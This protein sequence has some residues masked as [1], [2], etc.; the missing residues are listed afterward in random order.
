[1]KQVG[2]LWDYTGVYSCNTARSDVAP[3]DIHPSW[4]IHQK[5][6]VEKQI[7]PWIEKIFVKS[8][9][10]HKFIKTE[11]DPQLNVD[12]MNVDP[13]YR[14]FH[15]NLAILLLNSEVLPGAN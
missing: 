7:N 4:G 10:L 6:V 8:V 12:Y 9:F 15:V 2:A 3:W 13:M 14:D 11:T 1:M 5:D